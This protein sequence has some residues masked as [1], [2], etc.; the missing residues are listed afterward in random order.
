MGAWGGSWFGALFEAVGI[1]L[2]FVGKAQIGSGGYKS[3]NTPSPGN[4]HYAIRLPSMLLPVLSQAIRL[5][6]SEVIGK[7][8]MF[9]K[10]FDSALVLQ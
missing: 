4:L 10:S 2:A 1:A 5:E 6:L 7:P 3:D 8:K 9:T